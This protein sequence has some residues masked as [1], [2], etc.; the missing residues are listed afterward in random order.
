MALSDLAEFLKQ[1]VAGPFRAVPFYEPY[2]DTLILYLR[3]KRSCHKCITRS[4]GL[5]L[6]IEDDSLVGCEVKNVTPLL[7]K[8][9]LAQHDIDIAQL[10]AKAALEPAYQTSDLDLLKR[11]IPQLHRLLP[12]FKFTIEHTV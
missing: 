11:H 10:V 12:G 4:L 5:F 9:R 7:A 3:D 2:T 8:H 1:G 6:A